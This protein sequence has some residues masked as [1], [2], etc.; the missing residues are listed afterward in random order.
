MPDLRDIIRGR[1]SVRKYEDRQVPQEILNEILEAVKWAPSWTN[2]QC[3]E[4]I[5]VK[6]RS[7]R[8]KLQQT[9]PP[10]GNPAKRA[11]V[12]APVLLAVCAKTRSSGFYHDRPATKFGDWFMFDLGIACQNLCLT[13]YKHGLGTVITGLYDHGKAK[14]ILNVPLGY[15]QVVLIPVG[16]PAKISNAPKRR[17]VDEFVHQNTFQKRVADSNDIDR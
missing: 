3:W 8:E 17:E 7:I 5:I 15:E 9:L 1:R 4:I 14:E 6:D 13:A 11:I 12:D 2:N 10:K 16:Y